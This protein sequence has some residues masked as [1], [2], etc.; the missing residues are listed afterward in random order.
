MRKQNTKV[1]VYSVFAEIII[2]KKTKTKG[3]CI[4]LHSVS[5]DNKRIG[6]KTRLFMNTLIL[7]ESSFPNAKKTKK[8]TKQRKFTHNP[9]PHTS[10]ESYNH[11]AEGVTAVIR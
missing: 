10:V 11:C 8:T 1:H 9:Q 5:I 2:I 4:I 7:I 3:T 6:H